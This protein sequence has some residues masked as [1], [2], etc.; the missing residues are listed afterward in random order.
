[1]S[2]V[3]SQA[4]V[5]REEHL[6]ALADLLASAT[7][8]TPGLALLAGEAG[9]GKSRLL[10]AVEAR[11]RESGFLVLHGESVEFGGEDFAFA[12][13]VSALRRVPGA[14]LADTLEALGSEARALL[15]PLLPRARIEPAP[16]APAPDRDQ[17][18]LCELLLDLLGSL[19]GDVAPVLVALEDV[20]WADRSTRDLL[21]F[22]ARNLGG[23][24]IAV[25]VTCRTGELEVA[26]PLRRLMAE[27]ARRDNVRRLEL[28][29]LDRDEVAEQLEAIA[30]EPVPAAVADAVHARSGGNPLFVEELFAAH[31]A[32]AGAGIPATLQETVRGRIELLPSPAQHLLETLAAGGG[33]LAE[34]ILGRVAGGPELGPA[35]RA[36]ADAGLL[37]RGEGEVSLRHGLIGEVLYAALVEGERA[38]LHR[39]LGEALA[40]AGAPAAQLAEHWHRAGARADAL[41]ASVEAGLAATRVAAW[42]EARVHLARALTLWDD[43]RAAAAATGIDRV[44]LTTLAAQAARFSGDRDESL[45]L[46]R[47]ALAAVDR[48]E[49]PERAARL[50]ERLGE[51]QFWDDEAA[52]GCY[53]QALALLPDAATAERARVLAA[54]GHALM[55]LR[56]Y[57]E[58]RERCEAALDAADAARDERQAAV[59]RTTLGLVLAF[60]GRPEEGERHLRHALAAADAL[61]IA[62]ATARAHVHLGELLRLRGDHAGALATMQT[63]ADAAARAGMRGS[64]GAFME[65]NGADDLLRLGRW[66]EAEA[67]LEQTAR[68]QAGLTADALR[69]AVAGQLHAL[70]GRE[71]LARRHVERGL[72][73]V[74]REG[75]PGEFVVPIHGA[76]ATLALA[77]GD[78]A[79]ARRHVDRALA[80]DSARRDPLYTPL[81]L[82]LGVRA[83]ADAAAGARSLR[84]RGDAAE[85][86]RRAEALLTAL[87]EIVAAPGGAV[88]PDALAHRAAAAAER[89][90]LDREEDP[91]PWAAAAGAWDALA[92]PYP[93][94]YARLRG[95]EAL[96]VSGGGRREAATLLGA[97]HATAMALDAGPLAAEAESLARRARIA[98]DRDRKPPFSPAEEPL[99][100]DRETEVLALLAD[101]LTNREIAGRLFI[102]EK[103][104]GTHVG[105]IFDK[106]GVHNR[107][108][109]AALAR[110]PG[111][112]TPG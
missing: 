108:A 21:A 66:D 89:S 1:L 16:G 103:T 86:S 96:L 32:G 24:R 51:F 90:R 61:G 111:A 107:V 95:A 70:R 3:S 2:A 48:A 11:G 42:E 81:V 37:V 4:I 62:E 91:E 71:Q 58:A 109:A 106:L 83:E 102:S 45:A 7:S 68:R 31:R 38:A 67:R 43:D 112:A 34:S 36:A 92:E 59:T 23:E 35:V 44:E 84:R 52:L 10:A 63:G 72:E 76:A 13:V 57:E 12:P 47:T 105:H 64:F 77:A 25:A 14:W 27:L 15:A 8:G 87:A 56:R 60:L 41:S 93:A 39:A 50:Y 17:G 22:L 65:V 19:A 85:A 6:R 80:V 46:V 29:P 18:R 9:V 104:V 20:H 74:A 33:R 79:E 97:A 26:H 88:A 40:A 73:L 110:A 5:G 54:E 75:L 78:P 100:T 82:W 98:L 99:L 69:H 94:A 30:G 53:R 28:A 55:G 49:E 101:G